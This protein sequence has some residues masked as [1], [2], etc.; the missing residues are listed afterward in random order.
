MEILQLLKD[1]GPVGAI[2]V[3]SYL[4][5][6]LE[7]MNAKIEARLRITEGKAQTALKHAIVIRE[8]L[9]AKGTV[10]P[11]DLEDFANGV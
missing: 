9:I 3:T 2:L 8:T 5:L 10:K 4:I 6:R 7:V 11:A 1:W